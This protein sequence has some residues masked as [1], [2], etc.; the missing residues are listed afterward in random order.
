MAEADTAIL[1]SFGGKNLK[2][3]AQYARERC[4]NAVI[5]ICRDDDWKSKD[6][7]GLRFA[8]EAAQA[9]GGAI[10]APN[11]TGKRQDGDTDFNDLYCRH[12]GLKAVR[13]SLQEL[14]LV[15]TADA[16]AESSRD[17]ETSE[18]ESVVEEGMQELAQDVMRGLALLE[19]I[20][21]ERQRKKVARELGIRTSVLDDEVA[22]LRKEL[23][24]ETK[25]AFASSSL[26]ELAE[27]AREIIDSKDVLGAFLRAS[28][29][30]IAGE[31]TVRKM[32]YLTA[33]TRLFDKPMSVAIK[34]PSAAGKSHT[35]DYVL[36]FFPP[37]DVIQFTSLTEKAL[38]YFPGEFSHKILSLGE[39]GNPEEQTFQDLIVRQLMSEG[40]LRHLI[41]MKQPDG[42]YQTEVIEKR[43]PVCFLVTT[44]RNKLHEENETRLLSLEIDESVRQTRRVLEKLALTQ[45][46]NRPSAPHGLEQWRNFQRWLAQGETR[47]FVPFAAVLQELITDHYSLRLRRDFNQ[48]LDVIKGHA[49]LHREHRKRSNKGSIIAT[50]DEDYA[51]AE[52]LMADLMATAAEMKVRKPVLA[53][54]DRLKQMVTENPAFEREPDA[55]I[56]I[57]QFIRRFR[58]DRT[59][60]YR[61]LGQAMELGLVKN[62]ETIRGRP[63]RY[64]PTNEQPRTQKLLPTVEELQ[65]AY[66]ENRLSK[67]PDSAKSRKSGE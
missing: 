54:V 19:P 61:R 64:L 14:Q 30:G 40:V 62:M 34:G 32:L 28:E 66:A 27:S 17:N 31:E 3:A 12:G 45:G 50:I 51:V 15:T 11:F 5:T 16:D 59:G 55:G 21:Y 49:L 13:R 41:T 60:T 63:A 57:R 67:E 47:V 2:A 43:G 53:V 65:E 37:E 35:R 25:E 9:V 42:S 29:P 38:Y 1:M 7:P 26:D 10:A 22:A 52:S 6:N 46:L 24:S 58:L 18:D 39:A 4:P 20:G 56:T 36:R 23:A 33:T 44:T 48:L 8:M